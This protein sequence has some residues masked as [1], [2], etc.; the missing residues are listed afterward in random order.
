VLKHIFSGTMSFADGKQYKGFY[1]NDKR[2]GYGKFTWPDGD[3][4]EG[5]FIDDFR[6]G[7]G[8]YIWPDGDIY[9]GKSRCCDFVCLNVLILLLP[10]T[11]K[12]DALLYEN[13]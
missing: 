9:T 11:R 7:N 13:L 3:K 2:N 10:P 4:Y 8:T 5:F 6:T 12:K 1:E